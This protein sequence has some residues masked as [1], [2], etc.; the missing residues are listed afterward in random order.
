MCFES[1]CSQW[2][3]VTQQV[4]HVP[5]FHLWMLSCGHHCLHN[6]LILTC[7]CTTW[8]SRTWSKG[9][10]MFHRP[11]L[12]AATHHRY[13][14]PNMCSMDITIQLPTGQQCDPIK[15]AEVV[16]QDYVFVG[17]WWLYPRGNVANTVH[18]SK[19]HS[20]DLQSQNRGCKDRTPDRWWPWKMKN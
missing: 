12:K 14:V 10:W 1:S 11:L 13:N 19:H 17:R 6:A 3:L 16:Q 9:V 7:I 2:S 4:H 8:P 15:M 18:F 5:G 20:Y